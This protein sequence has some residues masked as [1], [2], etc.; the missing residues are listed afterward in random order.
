M[1]KRVGTWCVAVFAVVVAGC[2]GGGDKPK[3]VATYAIGG[4]VSGLAAG[5]TVVLQNGGGDDLAVTANGPFAFAT[6]LQAGA[7]YAV[8][9]KTQPAGQQCQVANGAGTASADVADVAVTCATLT[10]AV[11]GTL[12]GLPASSS[13]VLQNNGGDDLTLTANGVFGFAAKLAPGAAYAVTIK[14]APAGQTCTVSNGTGTM[15]SADVTGVTVTCGTTTFRLGGN[16]TGLSGTVVLASGTGQTKSISASGAFQFDTRI[17]TGASYA[18]TVQTQPTGQRCTVA[19][20]TGTLTADVSSVAVSC[21]GLF[22]VGGTVTGLASGGAI[23]LRNNGADDL[24]RNADGA[25]T[26]ATPVA[27]GGA[28]AVTVQSAPAGQT[29]AVANGGGNA[30]ASVTN[31]AVTCSSAMLSW[32]A[33]ATWG[34]VWAD[35][36]TMVQHA[37]FDANGIVSDKGPTFQMVGGAQPPRY[38]LQG[39]PAGTHHGA[40]PFA[41]EGVNYQAGAGNAAALDLGG[42][43]LV[44]AIVKPAR[45]RPFDSYESPIIAKGVGDGTFVVNAGGWVLMEMHESWCFHYEYKDGNGVS[46]QFMA[47]IPNFFADQDFHGRYVPPVQLPAEFQP[48][49]SYAVVC[50]GRRGDEVVIA[51]NA[52]DAST[53]AAF[54]LA[55]TQD[56]TVD[57]PF[58]G[59]YTLDAAVGVPATI[60]GYHLTSAQLKAAGI[61]TD[62]EAFT[63]NHVYNGLVFE[64][65]VWAQPATD[66][67]IAAKMRAFLGDAP[68]TKYL[69][70]REAAWVDGAGRLHFASRHAPRLDPVKGQLFGLQSWNRVSYWANGNEVYPR[71]MVFAAG[72]NLDLWQRTPATGSAA[73]VVALDP[74]V[75]R[76]GDHPTT[77]AQRVTL[78]AGASLSIDLDQA[79]APP[80]PPP[81]GTPRERARKTWDADGPIQGQLWLQPS[82]A[83]TLRVQK[84]DPQP[85]HGADCTDLGAGVRCETRNIDLGALTA[86]Q[87]NRVSLN[88]AFTADAT[89]DATTNRSVHPGRLVLTNPGSQP[90]S[91]H[92]FGVQ[93]TQLGGGGDLGSFDPAELMYDW[94]A[95]ATTGG[96]PSDDPYFPIDVVRLPPVTSGAAPS[97]FCLAAEATMPAGLPWSAPFRLARTAAVWTNAAGDRSAR[98]FV[99]G[100]DGTPDAGKLCLEVSGATARACGVIPAAW[101]TGAAKHRVKGCMSAA[102]QL[103][104]F[105]DEQPLGSAAAGTATPDVR[106]G[107]VLVGNSAAAPSASLTPWHGWISRVLVCQDTNNPNDCR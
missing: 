13:I 1:L 36:P 19:S 81:V 79:A 102:G 16:V 86:G 91:F 64:T 89:A 75:K 100:Q 105:G 84:T 31:V 57:N 38:A 37:H 97:G 2:S 85:G 48:N 44:C 76:P 65:A 107:T 106:N 18:V 50:G 21:V 94:S 11:R 42:D 74:A 20:G 68:G 45:N 41:A 90:I 52:V 4:A 51:A 15:A 47:S 70:N 12:S 66:A 29:C 93:L 8:T 49:P 24:T 82:G 53:L 56:Q 83:G 22:T 27:S 55:R 9:V 32:T 95:A 10:Y 88:G 54:S 99:A 43:M 35:E 61:A 58:R 25:F 23:V 72:E 59:P 5:G 77:P 60:G 96:E 69:R 78:P 46:H 73:P 28:Y 103:R 63:G 26:F 7:A 14:T 101:N 67:N 87:W 39:L 17:V 104:V 3:P 30:A 6:K 71:V 62:L 34:G 80:P 92:A 98:L 33:A 40:G